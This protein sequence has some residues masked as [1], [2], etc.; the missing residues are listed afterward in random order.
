MVIVQSETTKDP[1]SL[2]GRE[3][4]ICYGTDTADA[5]KNYKR[6]LQCFHDGHWRTMEWAQVYLVLDSYSA[7]CIRELYTHIGGAPTRLQASTRYIDYDNFAYIIPPNISSNPV[8]SECYINAM[9]DIAKSYQALEDMGISKEDTANLLPLGMTTKIVWRTNLRNLV[10]MC[11]QRL[12]NRAYWEI[13]QLMK[14]ILMSL[15]NYSPEWET[16]INEEKL[17][18]PKCEYLHECPEKRSCGYYA[19][20]KSSLEKQKKE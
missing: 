6:G 4:G 2:A 9:E 14:D 5:A 16:L 13:R 19:S 10:D 18:V 3:S 20:L 17:F 1:I 7:R 8:A 15:E 11:H 12:C